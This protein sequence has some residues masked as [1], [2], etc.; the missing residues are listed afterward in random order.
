MKITIF[1]FFAFLFFF[2]E[3][4]ERKETI[5]TNKPNIKEEQNQDSIHSDTILIDFDNGLSFF[6]DVK[7]ETIIKDSLC[8]ALERKSINRTLV[9]SISDTTNLH[10][11]LCCKKAYLRKGDIA[12]IILY[13]FNQIN[14]YEDLK[15]QFDDFNYCGYPNDLFDYL[16]E[17]RDTITKNLLEKYFYVESRDSF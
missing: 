14:L 9:N 5:Q 16:E 17:H 15:T 7:K 13:R 2:S 11:H 10:I 6:W 4:C 3:G 1:L 8:H 12:F